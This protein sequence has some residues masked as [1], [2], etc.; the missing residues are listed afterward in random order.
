MAQDKPEVLE[1]VVST[2]TNSQ[3]ILDRMKKVTST[4][5]DAKEAFQKLADKTKN[6]DLAKI[7]EEL[8]KL[9]NEMEALQNRYLTQFTAM[10]SKLYDAQNTQSSLTNF[11]T[12][13]TA[14][15]K[16]G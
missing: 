13:W 10:Q 11:M 12:A 1:A 15:M 2:D 4:A 7:D 14:G 6:T 3:G 5:L 9:N 8:E 16:N